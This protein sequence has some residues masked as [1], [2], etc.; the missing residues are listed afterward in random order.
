MW[1]VVRIYWSPKITWS[2]KV[3]NISI[4]LMLN[5][6]A[7]KLCWQN[8]KWIWDD[9]DI[10]GYSVKFG[11]K[12]QQN[13]LKKFWW[14]HVPLWGHWHPHDVSSGFQSQNGQS[15][16]HLAEVYMM[17]VPWDSPLVQHLPTSWWP[18]DGLFMASMAFPTAE[19]GCWIWLGD[20]PHNSETC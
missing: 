17:Y 16:L 12:R 20:L 2:R 5:N 13:F 8:K 6:W 11:W 19:V 10:C 4:K 15:Y 3:F 18:L 9:H 14:T 1:P 7:S